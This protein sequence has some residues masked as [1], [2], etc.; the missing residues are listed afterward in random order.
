MY[1]FGK[2]HEDKVTLAGDAKLPRAIYK[3]RNLVTS[4]NDSAS[5]FRMLCSR[6]SMYLSLPSRNHG[7]LSHRPIAS[8]VLDQAAGYRAFD[9]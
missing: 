9:R 6:R 4:P 1:P 2:H 8:A 7:A 3:F 5:P